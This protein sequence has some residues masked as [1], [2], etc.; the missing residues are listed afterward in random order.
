MG[1]SIEEIAKEN[2]ERKKKFTALLNSG[3]PI[4]KVR[5]EA[6]QYLDG[7]IKETMDEI[8]FAWGEE[9]QMACIRQQRYEEK[10]ELVEKAT[11][12]EQIVLIVA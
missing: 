9:L 3:A 4:E 12:A 8:D 7:R 10:K 2:V 6:I 5:E 1:N 11:S